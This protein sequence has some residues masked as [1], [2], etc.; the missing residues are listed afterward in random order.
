MNSDQAVQ[1]ETITQTILRVLR[2]IFD[3]DYYPQG[4]A[5]VLEQPE[6]FEFGRALP[7]IFLHL[8]CLGVIWTGWSPVAI[9]VAAALYFIRM[10]AITGFYHRYFS[11]KAFKTSRVAQF[12]FAV[13]GNTAVQRGPLWWAYVHRHHHKHSDHEE[14]MHSPG[15]KGFIWS[16][17]GW[18]TSSRNFPTRYEHVKDLAKYP[19]LVLLNRF[20]WIVPAIFALCLF[21]CGAALESFA[22]DLGTNGWQMLV[23]G[24]FIS[25]VVLL[26]AT[27]AINSFAHSFGK[28]V[29]NTDDES[30]NSLILALV[31]LGEG[32]H[33][34]HHRY[35]SSARQGFRWYELD[36]TYYILKLLSFTGLV[37]DLKPVPVQILEEA[38]HRASNLKSSTTAKS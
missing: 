19:E 17:I 20:D 38:Q 37:K 34:N 7:F 18:M 16:H 15:V 6:R 21:L 13:L 12:L 31:T 35:M 32:W 30:R 36:I 24:F 14:D 3:A 29:Y 23:W 2:Q 1:Q 9:L 27:L 22:P 28:K 33:N 11:H 25:T 10:F 5:R 8:G 26:H 4:V